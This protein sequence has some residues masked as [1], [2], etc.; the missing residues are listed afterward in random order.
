VSHHDRWNAPSGRPIE[1]MNIAAAYAAG[2]HLDERLSGARN[3]PGQV[4][5]F[6]LIVSREQERFHLSQSLVLCQSYI[7]SHSP[8]M[9]VRSCLTAHGAR[10]RMLG[11]NLFGEELARGIEAPSVACWKENWNQSRILLQWT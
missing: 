2:C 9:E 8:A 7:V 6:E 1:S 5:D 10:G 11:V 4:T 3:W